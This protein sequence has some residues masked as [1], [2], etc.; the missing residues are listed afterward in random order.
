VAESL[1][2][3]GDLGV[4]VHLDGQEGGAV[5]VHAARAGADLGIAALVAGDAI[6]V[7]EHSGLTSPG[8]VWCAG[9]YESCLGSAGPTGCGRSTP[10]AAGSPP[11]WAAQAALGRGR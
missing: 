3:G 1:D 2:A 10:A 11:G 8:V 9:F 6:V 7:G 5:L 4:P